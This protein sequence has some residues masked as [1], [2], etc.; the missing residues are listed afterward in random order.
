MRPVFEWISGR[1]ILRNEESKMPLRE[2]GKSVI[3]AGVANRTAF[4]LTSVTGRNFPERWQVNTGRLPEENVAELDTIKG[5]VYVIFSYATPI[6]W[7]V[8]TDDGPQWTVPEVRYSNSTNSHQAAVR[9]AV[10]NAQLHNGH[11]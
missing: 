2:H 7:C 6:A 3:A 10:A 5:P 9:K 4:A 1:E 11:K 8:E